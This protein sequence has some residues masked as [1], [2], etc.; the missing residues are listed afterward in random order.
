MK[1]ARSITNKIIW[2]K[3]KKTYDIFNEFNQLFHKK[4]IRFNS[5]DS[6][7]FSIFQRLKYNMLE[8]VDM[9]ILE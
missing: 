9:N 7:E 6:K 8:E 1:N 2:K 5:N 4:G 3:N